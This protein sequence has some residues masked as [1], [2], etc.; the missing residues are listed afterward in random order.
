MTESEKPA[1]VA[2]T[3]EQAKAEKKAQAK[4]KRNTLG[5]FGSAKP[6]SK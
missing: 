6:K 2:L 3:P 4:R 1:E 5:A